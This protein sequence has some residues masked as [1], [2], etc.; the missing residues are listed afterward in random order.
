MSRKRIKR[1]KPRNA[2]VNISLDVPPE[3]LVA[4]GRL[5]GKKRPATKAELAR[6]IREVVGDR[7]ARLRTVA[8]EETDQPAQ[9]EVAEQ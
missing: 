8:L 2:I 4:Y 7:L 9:P 6:L 3:D 5:L 1:R